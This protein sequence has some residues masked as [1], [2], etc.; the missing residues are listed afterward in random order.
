MSTGSENK[1]QSWSYE[2]TEEQSHVITLTQD[3]KK[4]VKNI[5]EQF[6][7]LDLESIHDD[8]LTRVQLAS[9]QLPYRIV[10]RILRF[11]RSPE[12]GVL[13]VRNLPTDPELP[14]TPKDARPS[15]QKKTHSSEYTLL[16]HMLFLGE[17]II[18]TEEKEGK[19]INDICP[20]QGTDHTQEHTGSKKSFPFHTE[21]AFHPYRPDHL[22]LICLRSDH[23]Q[24]AQTPVASII[25][26]LPLL[27]SAAIT[28]LRKP[29]YRIRPTQMF[30][31]HEDDQQMVA[32]LS[33][34]L[35]EP[36]MR[37]HFRLM[38][39][40]NPEAQWALDQLKS[41]LQQ[42]A[43]HYVLTPGD[44]FLINNR[45]VVHGRSTFTPCYDGNDRWI[46]R[47]FTVQ[48]FQRSSFSRGKGQHLC[49]PLHVEFSVH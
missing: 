39:G 7:P 25:D 49:V 33:G 20:V 43:L 5:I 35:L 8:L 21:N 9:F 1:L 26:A 18:Y 14:P 38:E 12:K 41:T 34:S 24:K 47:M 44:L 28:L 3:E 37:M 19:L 10:E 36:D 29:L 32:V 23:D 16:I 22:G 6:P 17:P 15:P 4:Q 45:R 2:N 27:P 31:H 48:D 42:V 30:K 40:I 11:R 13:L 46:Q